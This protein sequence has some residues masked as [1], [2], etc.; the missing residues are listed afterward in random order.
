MVNYVLRNIISFYICIQETWMDVDFHSRAETYC[1]WLYIHMTDHAGPRRCECHPEDPGSN[2]SHPPVEVT[3]FGTQGVV[4][5]PVFCKDKKDYISQEAG[6]SMK[7]KLGWKK[8]MYIF[9]SCVQGILE[10]CLN[11]Q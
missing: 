10:H 4:L 1:L 3:Q 6:K 8:I 7:L 2:F 5:V 11:T 9:Y